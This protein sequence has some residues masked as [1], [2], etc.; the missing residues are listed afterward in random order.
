MIFAFFGFNESFKGEAGLPQFKT[1][2]EKFI[3]ETQAA[4]NY[5]GHGAAPARALLADRQ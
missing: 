2:L 5:S 4:K 3:K 1:D